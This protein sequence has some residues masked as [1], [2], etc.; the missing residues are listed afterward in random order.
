MEV[1]NPGGVGRISGSYGA[2]DRA[3]A[4]LTPP[5]TRLNLNVTSR[6][7]LLWRMGSSG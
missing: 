6:R 3:G 5:A 7:L 2:G 1:P 4:E